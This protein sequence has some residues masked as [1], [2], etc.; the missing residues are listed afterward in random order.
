MNV[1]GRWRQSAG[2]PKEMLGAV[3]NSSKH[4]IL[5]R[6]WEQCRPNTRRSGSSPGSMRDAT[7]KSAREPRRKTV[8]NDQGR[9]EQD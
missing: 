7:G 4:R 5:G 9:L 8:S 2:T 6:R 1:G 3:R